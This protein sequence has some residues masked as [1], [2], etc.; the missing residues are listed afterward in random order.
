[1]D[2]D[3]IFKAATAVTKKWTKQRKAEVRRAD[4]VYRRN[5]MYSDRKTARDKAWEVIPGA[6]MKA[7][8]N[9]TLPALARQIMYAARGAIQEYTG[10]PLDDKYFTQT[11][12]PD[13]IN[14]HPE[15]T[16]DWDVVFDARGHFLEPHT[17]EEVP[18]GTLDVRQY[19]RGGNRD[20]PVTVRGLFPTRGPKNRFGAVMFIEKEGFFPLFHRTQLAERFDLAIMSTKGMSVVAARELV[21]ELCG[22]QGVPLMIL[23]DF[24]KSGFSILGTLTR[25]NRRYVFVNKPKDIKVIDLGL[26]LSDVEECGLGPEPVYMKGEEWKLKENLKTN[27]AT[28]EEIQFLVDER[29]RVELNAFDSRALVDWLEGKFKEHGIKKMIP[30]REVLEEAYRREWARQFV[31]ETVRSAREIAERDMH[32]I[33]VPW[34]VRKRLAA[35]LKKRPELPW[36]RALARLVKKPFVP[37]DNSAR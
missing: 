24:D 36:D 2:A 17:G 27:G 33:E 34:L 8:N 7:S 18:L 30:C 1:V 9:N 28:P 6:Y 29:Q 23:H 12:L 31:R 13:F 11:L 5:Y 32:Q 21:D 3:S 20:R 26:R 25:D 10:E 35:L 4:A 22:T 14:D 15:L 16:A 37:K 19:L